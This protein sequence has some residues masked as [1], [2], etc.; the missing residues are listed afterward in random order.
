ME[1]LGTFDIILRILAQLT[2]VWIAL[3]ATFTISITYKRRLGLYGK[4]FDSMIGMIGFALVMFWVFAAVFGAFDLIITHDSLSQVSGMKNKVPGT[5]LSGRGGR[6]IRL[7]PAGRRQPGARRFQP[8]DQGRMGRGA[9]RTAG[10]ALCLHGRHH[11]G[12]ACGILRRQA[13]H[14]AVFPGQPDPGLPGDLAVLPAGHAGN[15]GY[16]Y[17]QLHGGVHVRVPDHLCRRSC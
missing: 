6:R 16:G 12:P 13:G 9:D 17:S 2:P 14:G 4:L 15:R 8:H 3:V 1:P 7:V 11:A 10:D 5:P